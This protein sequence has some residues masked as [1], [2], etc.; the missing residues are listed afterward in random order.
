MEKIYAVYSG[1]YYDNFNHGYFKDKKEAEKLIKIFE[2]EDECDSEYEDYW[3]VEKNVF[4]N[5][6]EWENM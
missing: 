3:I 2:K 5:V 6:S 1:D 4:E